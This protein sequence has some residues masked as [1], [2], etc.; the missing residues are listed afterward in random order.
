MALKLIEALKIIG[1]QPLI[2]A[3]K[4]V[5]VRN[6]TRAEDEARLEGKSSAK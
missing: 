3:I 2:G 5:V 1:A 4:L 6:S